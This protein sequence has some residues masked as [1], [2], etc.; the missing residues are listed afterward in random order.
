MYGPK[1]NDETMQSKA[2]LTMI[3]ITAVALSGCAGD[4]P[5]GEFSGGSLAFATSGQGAMDA[6]AAHNPYETPVAEVDDVLGC[7]LDA[8]VGQIPDPVPVETCQEA[9][10]WFN[11]T[12]L[13]LPDGGDYMLYANGTAGEL[14]L[15]ALEGMNGTYSFSKEVKGS[16]H[17]GDYSELE[18]R[19]GDLVLATANLPTGSFAVATSLGGSTIDAT[20]SGKDLEY[21]LSGLPAGNTYEAW[22]V[23]E[24]ESGEMEH[25]EKWTVSN[26]AGSFQA[27]MNIGDFAE[28]HVHVAG[29]SIN[30]L[31]LSIE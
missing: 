16:D 12:S 2:L 19:I 14:H 20:Y 30:V 23:K 5:S 28:F 6:T 13:M 1:S 31:K 27:S 29:T 26:G 9:F 4:A 24:L 22:L 10:T 8:I 15:G 21:T 25:T 11:V 7:T 17:T 18:V 3:A